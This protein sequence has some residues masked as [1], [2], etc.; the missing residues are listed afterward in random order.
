[1]DSR[2]LGLDNIAEALG[3]STNKRLQM[4]YNSALVGRETTDL[5]IEGFDWADPQLDFSYEFLEGQGYVRAMATYVDL[6][7]EPDNRGKEVELAKWSGTIPRQKRK[8]VR[9]E[10]DY[11]KE[12]IAAIK[13]EALGRIANGSPYTSVKDYLVNSLFD[14][15]KE[16]PDSHNASLSYQVGQMKSIGKVQLTNDNNAGGLSG[17]EF[18]AQIPADNVVTENWYTVDTDNAV[19]YVTTADPVLTLKKKVRSLKLD[20]YQGYSDVTVELNAPTF[21]TI[22]EHPAVLTALGYYL[23]PELRNSASNDTNAQKVGYN[24]YLS[25]GDEFIKEFFKK[26]IGADKLIINTTIVGADKLNA[27]TKKFETAKLEAFNDGVVLVRPSGIIG[28]IFNVQPLRPDN[29]H[30]YADIFG[31][32]GI[33][34]YVYNPDTREQKWVSELTVLAVPTMPTK[35]YY[36]NVKGVTA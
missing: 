3:L 5:N 18:S 22:I 34:E 16:I 30:I 2:F 1:M 19:T 8:I 4:F 36:Y 15:L 29:S 35:M 23:R 21:Y 25:N 14:T 12:L 11:R 32:R 31:G 7:S 20:R 9:G 33:I 24:A 26:A 6:N 10:N 27:T 17:V 28:S 13:A